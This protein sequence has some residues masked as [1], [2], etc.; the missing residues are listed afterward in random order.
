MKPVPGFDSLRKKLKN[1][2]PEKLD[3]L[4][5]AYHEEVF[6]HTDCLSC[7][8][9]CKTISPAIRN[10]DI[11]RLSK[12]LK[13]KPSDLL[14]RYLYLDEEQDYVFKQA[15]CPFLL[16]DNKCEVYQNRPGACRQYPH[17][18]RVHMHQILELTFKNASV[19]P[20]VKEILGK[21]E[22]AEG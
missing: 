18:D 6:S 10:V 1:M 12:V 19:C 17:T 4:F 22:S 14:D 9:C 16:S 5:H 2:K 11:R 8:A 21:I 3:A 15:P 7:A 13:M 20:A